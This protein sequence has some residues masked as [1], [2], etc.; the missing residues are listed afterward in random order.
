MDP[1]LTLELPDRTIRVRGPKV[2]EFVLS[3]RTQFPVRRL[4]EAM[5][6]SPK[7]LERASAGIRDTERRLSELLTASLQAPELL[8]ER[9]QDIELKAFSKDHGWRDII[10]NLLRLGPDHDEYKRIAVIKY[11]QYLRSRQRALKGIFVE[12]AQDLATAHLHATPLNRDVGLRDEDMGDPMSDT[13]T[14][15][16]DGPRQE[17]PRMR[18]LPKGETVCI[19]LNG[20]SEV[21]LS[22]A[23]NPF[24][25]VAGR[26]YGLI[27]D[28]GKELPLTTGKNIIGRHVDC[29]IRVDPACRSVSRQHL[30]VEPVTEDMVLLT[31]VSAHGTQIPEELC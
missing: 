24:R 30:V 9:L 20:R 11:L 29:E 21:L 28:E 3:S 13:A 18:T 10:E 12:Q 25:L 4:L 19:R 15:A 7:R 6:W 23:G 2:L 1:P 8:G 16:P 26:R 5:R 31:D 14:L 22:L 27:D 17:L